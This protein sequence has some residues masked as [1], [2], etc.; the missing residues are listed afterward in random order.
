[1]VALPQNQSWN[2][3]SCHG[4][5]VKRFGLFRSGHRSDQIWCD[6]RSEVCVPTGGFVWLTG[7]RGR[8]VRGWSAGLGELRG[9]GTRRRRNR[10]HSVRFHHQG[11]RL[12]YVR[13]KHVPRQVSQGMSIT[14]R[15]VEICM[16]SRRSNRVSH[17]EKKLRCGGTTILLQTVKN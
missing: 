14:H 9:V 10:R 11:L 5:W 8:A 4:H 1:M 12:R 7:V 17:D 13:Q 2:W 6:R 16:Y 3:V 15:S